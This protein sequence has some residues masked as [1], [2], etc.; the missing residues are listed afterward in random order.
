MKCSDIG[1]LV[2]VNT[3]SIHVNFHIVQGFSMAH[4]VQKSGEKPFILQ[5]AMLK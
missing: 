2:I 3:V 1:T 5:L 4:T